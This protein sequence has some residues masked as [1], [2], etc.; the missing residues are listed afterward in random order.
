MGMS[1][2]G[3]TDEAFQSTRIHFSPVFNQAVRNNIV[4][5]VISFVVR[6]FRSLPPLMHKI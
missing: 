3:C 2:F 4:L 6:L 1:Y 5:D